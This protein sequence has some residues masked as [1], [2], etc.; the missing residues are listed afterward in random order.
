[1]IKLAMTPGRRRFHRL[2]DD[3]RD[4]SG[5]GSAMQGGCCLRCNAQR[6]DAGF[7]SGSNELATTLRADGP[8]IRNPTAPAST[9]VWYLILRWIVPAANISSWR[10]STIR[11]AISSA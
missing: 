9:A 2:Q 7:P 8:A 5:T 1:M 4:G 10:T 3:A 11:P 6:R